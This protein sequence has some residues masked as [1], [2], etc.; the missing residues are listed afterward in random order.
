MSL[1][2]PCSICEQAPAVESCAACGA[3]VC[4]RHY[5]RARGQCTACA[6]AGITGSH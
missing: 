3:V 2:G 5:V 4:E 6:A 1:S